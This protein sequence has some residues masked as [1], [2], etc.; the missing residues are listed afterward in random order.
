[1]ESYLDLNTSSVEYLCFNFAS[2]TFWATCLNARGQNIQVFHEFFNGFLDDV[3]PS[4]PSL[5]K[6]VSI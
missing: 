3:K 4:C 5:F 6:F 2:F 1:M